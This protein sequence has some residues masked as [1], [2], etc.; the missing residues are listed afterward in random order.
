MSLNRPALL[1]ILVFATALL[2]ILGALYAGAVRSYRKG[3][4]DVEGVRI[5]RWA[6]LGHAAIY[7]LLAVTAFLS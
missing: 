2:A 3:E 7:A 1:A 4:L 5:L 6:L